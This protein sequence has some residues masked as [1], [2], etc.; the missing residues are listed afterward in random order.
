MRSLLL[1]ALFCLG[2]ALATVVIGMLFHEQFSWPLLSSL[3][4][5]PVTAVFE[6][7][8]GALPPA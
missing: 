1:R 6:A 5:A 2:V 7:L 3:L 4:V 8:G